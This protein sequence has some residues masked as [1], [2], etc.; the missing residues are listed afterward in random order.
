MLKNHKIYV[1]IEKTCVY[2]TSKFENQIRNRNRETKKR[3][4]TRIMSQKDKKVEMA[5]FMYQFVFF[6]LPCAF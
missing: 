6:V 4:P 1:S 5:Q 2:N 3:N